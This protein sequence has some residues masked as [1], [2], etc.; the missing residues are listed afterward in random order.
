MVLTLLA[1]IVNTILVSIIIILLNK[2]NNENLEKII[3]NQISENN[4]QN[5]EENKRKFDEIE[6]S[7]NLGTKN[8]LLE[9]TGNIGILLAENNEKMLLRFNELGQNING[10]INTNNQLLSK[11]HM[12]NSQRLTES[13]NNAIQKLSTGLN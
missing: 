1:I 3:L 5:F 12:E 9:G 10:T 7:I 2:K 6:K 13:M 4:R 11:N 8:S